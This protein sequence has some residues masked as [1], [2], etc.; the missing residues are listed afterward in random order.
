VAHAFPPKPGPENPPDGAGS[1]TFAIKK[2]YLGDTNP[3]G[4][5]NTSSGWKHYGFDLDGIAGGEPHQLCQPHYNASHK[6]THSDGD[7]GIDNSFGRNLLPILRSLS[8]TFSTD[9][10]AAIA[11]GQWTLMFEIDALG[12]GA[13]YNPLKGRL[14]SGALLMSPPLF[15][16]TDVWPIRS[17]LLQDPADPSSAK[18]RFPDSYLVGNTWVGRAEGDITLVLIGKDLR[19]D[20]PV[21]RAVVTM[22]LDGS[23]GSAT[24]GTLAGLIPLGAVLAQSHRVA[25]LI[26]P[27]TCSDPGLLTIDRQ[28]AQAADILADG[29]QDPARECESI[30]LGIGFEAVRVTPGAPADPLPPPDPGCA[31]DPAKTCSDAVASLAWGDLCADGEAYAAYLDLVTC[32][33]GSPCSDFCGSGQDCSLAS[34]EC[35]SCLVDHDTGCGAELDACNAK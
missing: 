21:T 13:D 23:H 12:S 31:C 16:G 7:A 1:A 24:R 9:V 33:C 22:D 8:T 34:P 28:L 11:S 18:V 26:F 29:T 35:Q 2:L 17:D 10:N 27:G 15:D 14:H 6:Y 32:G 5:M 19:V 20:L 4:T 3:D 30:T 25:G